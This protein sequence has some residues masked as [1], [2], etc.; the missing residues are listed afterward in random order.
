MTDWWFWI[1]VLRIW[2]WGFISPIPNPKNTNPQLYIINWHFY[3]HLVIFTFSSLFIAIGWFFVN[4]SYQMWPNNSSETKQFWTVKQ[5]LIGWISKLIEEDLKSSI[6]NRL[7]VASN[8]LTDPLVQISSKHCQSQT[9][10]IRELKFRKNVHPT[11][12]VMCHVSMLV[13][14]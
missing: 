13:F 6:F 7:G 5:K 14:Q 12:C 10:R 3:H 1:G 4:I 9:K 11:I 2:D 8:S